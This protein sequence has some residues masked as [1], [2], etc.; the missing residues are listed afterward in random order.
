MATIQDL[1]GSN[2]VDALRM[3]DREQLVAGMTEVELESG[4]V[5]YEPGDNVR[6]CYFP[7]FDAMA[8]FHVAMAN[9]SA[10]ETGLVGREGAIG[11]IVSQGRLPAFA[12]ASVMHGGSFY[13][14]SSSALSAIKQANHRIAYLFARYADCML[15]QTFQSVACN[16][17]HTIEQRSA[18][19][20]I[21]MIDR[22]G[23]SDVA[24]TQ[25]ELGSILGVGRSYVSRVIQR[26]KRGGLIVTR[27]GHIEVIDEAGLRDQCC[28]CDSLVVDH[29]DTVLRGVYPSSD[30]ANLDSVE[31]ECA[32]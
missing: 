4:H 27:R 17:A 30:D 32:A 23:R 2:L 10:I 12:R 9:G 7:R 13:R 14:I 16:A 19:W 6:Y 11:G 5:L 29:F 25:D 31:Q 1:S 8:T 26:L 15:A 20:L 24:M 3:P 28:D 21:A 22:T 18:K